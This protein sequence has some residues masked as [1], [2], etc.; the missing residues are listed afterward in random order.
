MATV[1]VQKTKPAMI[2]YAKSI[3]SKYKAIAKFTY[4]SE[5]ALTAF[6][7]RVALFRKKCSASVVLT[8]DLYK[9]FLYDL[10]EYLKV[11]YMRLLAKR[12]YVPAGAVTLEFFKGS[13]DSNTTPETGTIRMCETQLNKHVI[14]DSVSGYAA[15]RPF[16]KRC[17]KGKEDGLMWLFLHE[18]AHLLHGCDEHDSP[19]FTQ[20]EEFAR[21]NAFL[22]SWTADVALW[23]A[24]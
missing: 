14:D 5:E 3:P 2:V 8:P 21:E 19:F 16:M 18:F 24:Q 12:G 7:S 20:V 10:L 6:R 4:D 23:C 11:K 15:E 17:V 9:P 1:G 22:F 13:G